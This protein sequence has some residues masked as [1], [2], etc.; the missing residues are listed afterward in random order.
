MDKIVSRWLYSVFLYWCYKCAKIYCLQAFDGTNI[1]TYHGFLS[2][3]DKVGILKHLIAI[4]LYFFQVAYF[5]CIVYFLWTLYDHTC[6]PNL[7][8]CISTVHCI[9]MYF[10]GHCIFLLSLFYLAYMYMYNV[11]AVRLSLLLLK[12]T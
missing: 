1:N 6:G 9:C 4:L 8:L 11:H 3:L 10:S 2:S 5:V 12:A 7:L